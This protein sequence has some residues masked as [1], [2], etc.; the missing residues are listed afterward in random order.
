[1]QLGDLERARDSLEKAQQA[2]PSDPRVYSAL[3][4]LYRRRGDARTAD[5]SYGFALRYEKDHPESL[6]GR[7]L[8]ALDSDNAAGFPGG[9]GDPQEAPRRR[10]PAVARGS[11]PSRT[12]LA[13]CW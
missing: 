4:T 1:M 12:S 6:L 10:P 3:G 2:A 9:R 5:Q 11:S 7:A 8:L 13:P